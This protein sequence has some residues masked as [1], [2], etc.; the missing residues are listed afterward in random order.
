MVIM[1]ARISTTMKEVFEPAMNFR[2]SGEP[3]AM[4][5]DALEMKRVEGRDIVAP[6][7]VRTVY[8]FVAWPP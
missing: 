4:G 2:S 6:S 1:H 5:A 3:D 8:R 7:V